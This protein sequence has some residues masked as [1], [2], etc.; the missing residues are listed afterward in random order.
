MVFINAAVDRIGF[1][2]VSCDDAMAT[3]QAFDHLVA[4]GHRHIALLLG[5]ADHVPSNRNIAAALAAARA[6]GLKLP[7]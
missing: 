7:T 4:L 1:P 6:L 2:R 5:P 3:E